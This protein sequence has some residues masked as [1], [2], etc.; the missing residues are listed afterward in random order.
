VSLWTPS[1]WHLAILPDGS[2]SLGYGSNAF[3]VASVAARTFDFEK[4]HHSLAAVVQ[5]HGNIREY[6]AVGFEVA[7][8]KTVTSYYTNRVDVVGPLFEAAKMHCKPIT[9]ER[10]EEL[11]RKHAPTK[12]VT[13]N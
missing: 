8:S 9:N 1:G 13:P 4:V 11:W 7:G 5:P 3:D 12:I 2:A 6:F 10:F